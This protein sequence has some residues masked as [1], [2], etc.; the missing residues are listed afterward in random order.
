MID[1]GPACPYKMF[2][3]L[4][5]SLKLSALSVFLYLTGLTGFTGFT[6]LF[7]LA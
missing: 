6:G 7:L 1:A 3:S 4:P 2:F 5:L